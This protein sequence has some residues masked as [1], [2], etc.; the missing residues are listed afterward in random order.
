MIVVCTPAH[1]DT[2]D[3]G[4]GDVSSD[5]Q[6]EQENGLC[7]VPCVVARREPLDPSKR[8]QAG[9]GCPMGHCCMLNLKNATEFYLAFTSH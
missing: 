8:H 5:I 1:V 3:Y 2:G 6:T 4:Y 7:G 9:S